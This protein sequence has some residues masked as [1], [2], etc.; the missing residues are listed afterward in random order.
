MFSAGDDVTDWD[1]LTGG[2]ALLFVHGIFSSADDTFHGLPNGTIDALL[3]HYSHRVFCFDHPTVTVSP[4]DNIRWLLNKVGDAPLSLDVIA[5]SRGGLVSR[6][7]AGQLPAPADPLDHSRQQDRVRR[8]TERR[9]R[10]R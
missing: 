6:I 2:P 5:H 1:K 10:D 3:T 8:D 7:L 9:H 4:E